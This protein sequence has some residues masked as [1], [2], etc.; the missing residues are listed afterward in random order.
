LSVALESLQVGAQF[1]GVLVADV[2]I[3]LQRL[4]DDAFQ[5]VGNIG[6]QTHWRSWRPVQN[7]VEGGSRSVATEWQPSGGHFVEHHA[8]GEKIGAGVNVFAPNLLGRHVGDGAHRGPWT[9]EVFR[10]IAGHGDFG[11]AGRS[12]SVRHL[13]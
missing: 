3:F 12:W 6:I 4:V 11:F 2:T 10:L 8:E 7:G 9:G 1:R 5:A 13:G